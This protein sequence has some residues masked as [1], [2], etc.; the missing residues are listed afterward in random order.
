MTKMIEKAIE[1]A[2]EMGMPVS[3]EKSIDGIY[4]VDVLDDGTHY[5][6]EENG[7][8][9]DVGYLGASSRKH[10]FNNELRLASMLRHYWRA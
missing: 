10:T 1:I 2:E 5:V 7:N 8:G 3:T 6:I 4:R 9:V